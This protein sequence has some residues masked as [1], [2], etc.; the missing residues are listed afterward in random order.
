MSVKASIPWQ[1]KIAAKIILS[2]FSIGYESWSGL[3]LFRHGKMDQSNYAYGVFKQHFDLVMPA[4]GFVSLELGPGDTLASVL[5]SKAFG[6]SASYLVDA[7][8]FAQK[9]LRFYRELASLLSEKGQE[10]PDLQNITSLQEL[11]HDCGSKYLTKGVSSLRAIPTQSVDFVYSHAVLEHVKA[12]EFLSTMHELRRVIRRKG[13]CSHRVDLQD[14]LGG[15]LNNLRFSEQLWESV[16]MSNSGFYT[17]RIRFSEMMDLFREANFDAR[18]V[19]LDRWSDLPT[20]R[21]RL[22]ERFK[23]LPEDDLRIAGFTVILRP[24]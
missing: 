2:R 24:I 14:H 15:A 9:D 21:A 19:K 6:G 17:N 5:L 4:Q 8:E 23:Q 10:V 3:G 20:P 18:V 16:L 22:S 7:G 13:G 12:A 1:V 11:L